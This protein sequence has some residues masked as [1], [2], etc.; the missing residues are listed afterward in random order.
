MLIYFDVGDKRFIKYM[1]ELLGV[2][3]EFFFMK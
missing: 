1:D 3:R 2:E